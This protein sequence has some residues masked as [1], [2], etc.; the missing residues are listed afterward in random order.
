MTE[1]GTHERIVDKIR[2]QWSM[3]QLEEVPE[4]YYL[5]PEVESSLSMHLQPSYWSYASEICKL[6]PVVKKTS[7]YVRID[8]YWSKIG[9]MLNE[10]GNLKYPQLFQLVKVVLSLSHG[11][12]VPERG[13]SINKILLDAHGTSL[14][15][16]TITAL[17]LGKFKLRYIKFLSNSNSLQKIPGNIKPILF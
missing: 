12:S 15:E 2:L 3:Y 10:S 16:D 8:S 6:A 17:R 14:K 1:E 5:K 13:F 7:K 11:N 4:Q 9:K